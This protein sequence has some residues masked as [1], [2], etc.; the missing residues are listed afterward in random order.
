MKRIIVAALA[1]ALMA[2]SAYAAEWNFYG[3]AMVYTVWFQT[4]EI[5]GDGGDTQF[6]EGLYDAAA[7]GAEI[8]VSDELTAGFEYDTG[9]G[10]ANIVL[11]YGEWTFSSGILTVGQAVSPINVTYS[12]QLVAGEEQDLGLGG[13]GD[14]DQAEVPQLKLTFGGFSIAVINPEKNAWVSPA[15]LT[16]DDIALYDT[17]AVIPMIALCYKTEF[18]M[19]EVQIAAGYNTF[20][21]N[22][23]EDIDA[24]AIGLGTKLNFGAFGVFGTFVWGQ[25]MGNLGVGIAAGY[26]GLAIYDGNEVYDCESI[27]GTIGVNFAVNDMLTLEAG[28][29]YIHDKIDDNAW[30]GD[31]I[32]IAQSYYLQA[33]ITLA[34]GVTVT[35]EVGMIDGRE[36][37]QEETL[38]FGAAWAI[39][40]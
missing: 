31:E 19:G 23:D 34:P 9:G 17:Q 21:V 30:T 33:A 29:G 2:G 24:Y 39:A 32:D 15:P 3:E 22:D 8:K 11:L 37:G 1:L 5:D 25:N 18:D 20:E 26:E 12:N 36:T 13:F 7:I 10:T 27:G 40:F 38:Y 14:F 28:Y 6:A 35:P 4:D 16:N